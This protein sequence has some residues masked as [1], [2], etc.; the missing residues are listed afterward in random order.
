MSTGLSLF[1]GFI[2]GL[3][4]AFFNARVL[5]LILKK[6]LLEKKKLWAYLIMFKILI[7]GFFIAALVVYF[8]FNLA[9]LLLGWFT[10]RWLEVIK[11]VK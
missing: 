1:Y 11:T 4:L 6:I 9:A 2:C 8:G 5:D 10:G 7:T 3:I